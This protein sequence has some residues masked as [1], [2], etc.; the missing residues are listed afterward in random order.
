[1]SSGSGS[2]NEEITN[3][4]AKLASL[5]VDEVRWA[6]GSGVSGERRE[7]ASGSAR[8]TTFVTPVPPRCLGSATKKE[9]C[10]IRSRTKFV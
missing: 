3:G 8:E 7:A 9:V 1:M 4:A 10:T 2:D 6:H 5:V